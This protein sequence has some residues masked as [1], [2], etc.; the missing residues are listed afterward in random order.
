MAKKD[1]TGGL[2]S[3]IGETPSEQKEQTKTIGRP[4][5]QAKEITKTSQIGTKEAETRA[6]FI[7]NEGLLEK[8][9]AIAYWDRVQIKDVV[10]DALMAYVAQ[11]EKK[12][13]ALKNIPSK[14]K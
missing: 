14:G 4:V 7:V 6:T 5:T 3:L 2:S 1:F 12:N 11:Y 9:K 13:G 10:G 8:V